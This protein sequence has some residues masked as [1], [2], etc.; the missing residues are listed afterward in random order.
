MRRLF[1]GTE[2]FS[3]GRTYSLRHDESVLALPDP[4]KHS[5]ESTLPGGKRRLSF[6]RRTS[7]NSTATKPHP[8]ITRE[9]LVRQELCSLPM[10]DQ[11]EL[12]RKFMQM[13]VS[14]RTRARAHTCTR[15]HTTQPRY[16][17]I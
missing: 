1:G 7:S 5:K 17:F 2:S 9:G 6:L 3:K 12:D 13:V 10:P 16:H 8:I 11:L 15:M 4:E 14:R